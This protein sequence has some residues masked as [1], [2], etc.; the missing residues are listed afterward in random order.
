MAAGGGRSG[1]GV[2]VGVGDYKGRWDLWPVAEEFK[3]L[4][5]VFPAFVSVLTIPAPTPKH[6]ISFSNQRMC[7]G[8]ISAMIFG[9]FEAEK[10]S[11]ILSWQH[12]SQLN[13]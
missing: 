10:K 8:I 13:L 7:G 3:N 2:G 12:I 6:V 11:P 4:P 5:P 9:I 1:L